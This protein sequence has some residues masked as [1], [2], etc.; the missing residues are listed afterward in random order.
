MSV[1]YGIHPVF[2]DAQVLY[3]VALVSVRERSEI[4][5]LVRL[6][7]E[8]RRRLKELAARLDDLYRRIGR[9]R[10][11]QIDDG[12]DPRSGKAMKDPWETDRDQGR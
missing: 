8:Q 3:C 4:Q 7:S 6:A 11:H 10:R 9:I 1:P 12:P 5:T 2:S